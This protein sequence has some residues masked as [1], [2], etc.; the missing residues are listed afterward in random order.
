MTSSLSVEEV[1]SNLEQRAAFHRDQEALHAQQEGH[2]REQRALH[3]AELE[4]V[5]QSLD[6]FRSVA[7]SA[8]ELARPVAAAAATVPVAQE[9]EELPPPGRFMVARLLRLV[10]ESATFPEP[11]GPSAVA[12]EANRRF[13]ERLSRAIGQRTASDVLRRL[14]A[15]GVIKLARKGTAFH[16]GLYT[17]RA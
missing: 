9:V 5:Q 2:H 17:R 1:L 10:A 16:E 3:A 15:E 6:A 7:A 12:A 11:F 8:V 4:K 13:R 14:L